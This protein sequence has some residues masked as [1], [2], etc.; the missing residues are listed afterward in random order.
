MQQTQALWNVARP[1]RAPAIWRHL[2]T[3]SAAYVRI[4]YDSPW[5]PRRDDPHR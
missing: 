1:R 3:V 5:A 4:A 2:L